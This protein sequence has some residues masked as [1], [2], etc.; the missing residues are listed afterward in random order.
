MANYNS[1][2]TGPQIDSAVGLALN[3]ST[4]ATSG[5]YN[6]L[7]N[8]PDLLDSSSIANFETTTELNARDTANRDRANHTGT[9][10]A[11]TISNFDS[12]V[13]A[14]IVPGGVNT[15]LQYNNNG[16]FAGDSA[17]AWDDVQKE[18]T[19]SGDVVLYDSAA[20][21]TIVQSIPATADRVISFPDATGV[22]GLVA[23]TDGQIIFNSNSAYSASSNLTFDSA[24]DTL[25]VVNASV[26]GTLTASKSEL[27]QAT[28][29]YAATTDIDFATVTGTYQTISLTGDV[30]FTTSNRAAGRSVV[31]RILSNDSDRN[32]TFP[33]GWKFLGTLA[34]TSITA[35]KTAILSITLFGTEDS[36]AVCAYSVEP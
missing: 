7:A 18:L 34:P 36:D 11:S 3:L 32:F 9:Q 16:S 20:F 25:S 26:T 8:K 4:V 28:L 10:L 6:D 23:G 22:V 1:I 15:H 14:R 12:A 29:S 27:T 24:T 35:N 19:V 33:A 2:Y 31:A 13:D 21:E 30:T 5:D 17:L